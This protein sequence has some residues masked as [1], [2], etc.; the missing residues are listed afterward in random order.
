M[1][2]VKPAIEAASA[3]TP[4]G[5]LRKLLLA[6]TELLNMYM[7]KLGSHQRAIHGGGVFDEDLISPDL[8]EAQKKVS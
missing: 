8:A 3:G 2:G 6:T 5:A 7:P 1:V 4:E